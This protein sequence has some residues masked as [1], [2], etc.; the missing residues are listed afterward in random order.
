MFERTAL[1]RVESDIA[2][3]TLY[4]EPEKLPALEAERNLLLAQVKEIKP[5]NL[6]EFTRVLG[7]LV[8]NLDGT[9]A[10]LYCTSI[11]ENDW[12]RIAVELRH[13][14][15]VLG[16]LYLSAMARNKHRKP[17]VVGE[18]ITY[19]KQPATLTAVGIKGGE[20]GEMVELK[21]DGSPAV[22][23]TTP[24]LDPSFVR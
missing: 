19:N 22:T 13:A 8:K 5:M 17:Y 9:Q 21:I 4:G 11:E 24:G 2:Y 14:Q 1:E 7:K 23:R 15:D 12:D 3:A 16:E 6:P 10:S 20:Y 18:R